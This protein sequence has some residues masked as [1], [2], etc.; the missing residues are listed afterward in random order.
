ME[1]GFRCWKLHRV[2]Q[3]TLSDFVQSVQWV[4]KKWRQLH[5]AVENVQIKP[6]KCGRGKNAKVLCRAELPSWVM[7]SIANVKHITTLPEAFCPQ[8]QSYKQLFSKGTKA[9]DSPYFSYPVCS[10]KHLKVLSQHAAEKMP[11]GQFIKEVTGKLKKKSSWRYNHQFHSVDK[12]TFD[13]RNSPRILINM[14][15]LSVRNNSELL[16]RMF[17]FRYWI[18]GRWQNCTLTSFKINQEWNNQKLSLKSLHTVSD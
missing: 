9:N 3:P 11:Q 10:F 17:S 2:H 18:A 6:S 13:S 8:S 1:N 12:I 5:S 16:A 14:Y 7:E 4:F 15:I